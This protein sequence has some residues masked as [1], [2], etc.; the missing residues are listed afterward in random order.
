MSANYTH[1]ILKLKYQIDSDTNEVVKI[2]LPSQEDWVINLQSILRRIPT[3]F[4]SLQHINESQWVLYLNDTLI[5]KQD[6]SQ[7]HIMLS[8]TPPIA[9]L[10][11]VQLPHKKQ[12]STSKNTHNIDLKINYKSSSMLWS[13]VND[14]WKDN[15]NDLVQ[16][17]KSYFHHHLNANNDFKL[18]DN[19]QCEI[20]DV[21]DLIAV[22][23]PVDNENTQ[24]IVDL[25]LIIQPKI[26]I[27]SADHDYKKTEFEMN[28]SKACNGISHE[29][30]PKLSSAVKAII[31][32]T[33]NNI[34]LQK[35]DVPNID[36]VIN[37]LA[38]KRFLA[39]EERT[40]L[41]LFLARAA[42]FKPN[43][44][45]YQTQKNQVYTKD[46]YSKKRN[47]SDDLLLD[48]FDVHR[49]YIFSNFNCKEYTVADF[50]NDMEKRDNGII[51]DNLMD[52]SIRSSLNLYPQYI[53]ND[54]IFR[55]FD[56]HFA[57]SA[58]V[59]ELKNELYLETNSCFNIKCFV[60][61]KTISCIYDEDLLLDC[62]IGTIEDYLSNRNLTCFCK[63]IT[64]LKTDAPKDIIDV[65]NHIK[66][67]H[68][69]LE[70]I[71]SSK[72]RQLVI[73]FD[74]RSRD[75]YD[76][77][78]VLQCD[79]INEHRELGFNYFVGFNFII[80][81]NVFG[82][83]NKN[84][85]IAYFMYGN[86]QKI[87]FYPEHLTWN[88]P[89]IF[90]KPDN[91]SAAQY[92][93]K[94]Y[95]HE[96]KHGWC[97]TLNDEL[98]NHYYKI[99]T[100]FDHVSNNYNRVMLHNQYHEKHM[101]CFV[102]LLYHEMQSSKIKSNDM[103][104]LHNL[105]VEFEFDS[106]SIIDDIYCTDTEQD[107]NTSN[108]GLYLKNQTKLTHYKI[109]HE[110]IRKYNAPAT[111]NKLCS[112]YDV[113]SADQCSYVKEIV[114]ALKDFN[115]SNYDEINVSDLLQA[116]DHVVSIHNLCHIDQNKLD[117]NDEENMFDYVQEQN[118][119]I[120]YKPFEKIE[121][122]ANENE[123]QKYVVDV[124]GGYCKSEKCIILKK[125][126]TRRREQLIEDEH[127]KKDDD[128]TVVD[129]IDEILHAT[130]NAL[131]CYILHEKKQLF[132]LQRENGQSHF[133]TSIIDEN[134]FKQNQI[135]DEKTNLIPTLNF[136]VSVLQWLDHTERSQF[137]N[138]HEEIIQNPES[139]IS[140]QRYLNYGQ[141]CFIKINNRKYEQYL[142]TE[143]MSVKI[144]TDT[145]SFQSALRRAFWKSSS[146]KI[147]MLF[148]QWALQ[149]Y[150]T[151]LFHATPIPRYNL[152][153]KAPQ[154]LFHGL[155]RV[156][157][158]TN[159][160]PK[161][162][163]VTS[164][165]LEQSVAHSFTNGA[166]LLWTIKASYANKFKFVVGIA[167]EWISQHKNEREILLMDQYFPISSVKNFEDDIKNNVDHLLYTLKSYK[168]Q[169]TK[170]KHFYNILGIAFNYSWVPFIRTHKLLFEITDLQDPA[171]TVLER[172]REELNMEQL[173]DIYTLFML[174][175]SITVYPSFKF[176]S[177][178]PKLNDTYAINTNQKHFTHTKFQVLDDNFNH[179]E[180]I[181][182]PLKKNIKYMS[183]TNQ[184]LVS[185]RNYIQ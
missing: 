107:I 76:Y 161:Y 34:E 25:H 175:F 136:G 38:E 170:A 15:Y 130:L 171:K 74:R 37:I 110:I 81:R 172:L 87:R 39:V 88:I 176:C 103:N 14:N 159:P 19:D 54:D 127:D 24:Q 151:S 154:P 51:G 183:Q 118:D 122:D 4:R 102:D 2:R 101:L 97:V 96:F 185:I 66:I 155:N 139:T 40:Y 53:V 29:M 146:K 157:V 133:I 134:E 119:D 181:I 93:D 73:I 18:Q 11:I 177:I 163:G 135:Q 132:R 100:S 150:K 167:V 79:T 113:L 162:N 83:K 67:H 106:D 95:S 47:V 169:I 82:N 61:P 112:K 143:M 7:F 17:V 28:W 158:L 70:D 72:S 115:K 153:T 35:I 104:H 36:K 43:T 166:G 125:H 77:L 9:V 137:P 124:F 180:V 108:I 141:E 138:F 145:N 52:V 184:F 129:S 78:Y 144:Y 99:V 160:R 16:K 57:V 121:F 31:D 48:I 149:M 69:N 33:K 182:L 65:V 152:Q 123:I 8:N 92:L 45:T 60:I 140:E 117:N 41:R 32:H 80:C 59:N 56:Y 142:L 6:P 148:F 94:L 131:H 178:K 3:K 21:D 164:T 156:F 49:I 179:N 13:V 64:R 165:S 1:D 128:D 23:K 62:K 55:I 30:W 116:Y 109:I 26:E 75:D 147:K 105:F 44:N 5:N 84:K 10:Q 46:I 126:M 42:L 68:C 90:K 120:V 58:F 86:N 20:T 27:K 173:S 111:K 12:E 114:D 168:K 85:V 50:K 91:L 22:C 98:F 63:T 174:E 89:R 71:N